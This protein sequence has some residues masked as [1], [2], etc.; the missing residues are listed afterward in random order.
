MNHCLTGKNEINLN[1]LKGKNNIE[2]YPISKKIKFLKD[3]IVEDYLMPLFTNQT[4][5]LYENVY[6]IDTINK[7]V[8]YYY[9]TYKLDDLLIYMELLKV[10]KMLIENYKTVE[11]YEMKMNNKL[12]PS[13]VVSMIFKTTKI[14]LLPEYEIYNSIL[15]K[16]NRELNEVYNSD[17]IFEIKK[18]I[19]QENCNYQK[20]KEYISINYGV[21]F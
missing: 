19:N 18:L 3:K 4:N 6:F 12:N 7:K 20:I 10:I 8:K 2:K 21:T 9:E 1:N 17:I 16:P 11:N 15:G 13:E 14:R 5:T